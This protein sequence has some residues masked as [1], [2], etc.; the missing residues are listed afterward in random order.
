VNVKIMLTI[1]V[2][3]T[4]LYETLLLAATLLPHE[5]FPTCWKACSYCSE[6]ACNSC[7]Q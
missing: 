7:M 4:W 3:I 1:D 2:T 6:H 5:Y